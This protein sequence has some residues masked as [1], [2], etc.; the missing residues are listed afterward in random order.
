MTLYMSTFSS[1]LFVA[2]LKV[3]LIESVSSF[4]YSSSFVYVIKKTCYVWS[5]V[6]VLYCVTL[7]QW[8][9]YVSYI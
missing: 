4:P 9:M 1:S 3:V 8:V 6:Y 2:C 7:D 5:L